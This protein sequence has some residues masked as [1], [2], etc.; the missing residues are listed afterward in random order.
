M[1]KDLGLVLACIGGFTSTMK[2]T[3]GTITTTTITT[4][5]KI[6]VEAGME[7]RERG[8]LAAKA[9]GQGE[10]LMAAVIDKGKTYE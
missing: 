10:V 5:I 2:P 9:A 8:V 7:E 1:K 3:T 4:T 6:I